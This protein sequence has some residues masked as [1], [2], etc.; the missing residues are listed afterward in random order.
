MPVDVQISHHVAEVCLRRPEKH[1]GLNLSM[2]RELNA[3]LDR[4]AGEDSLRAVVLR[5]EGPSFCAGLDVASVTRDGVGPDDL[6]IPVEGSLANLAQRAAYGWTELPV[7]VIAALHGHCLGAGLQIALG[8]DIRFASPDLVVSVMEIKWGLI[9]DMGITQTLPRLVRADIAKEL[10]WT[11][12]LVQA[13]EAEQ[14]GLVTRVVEDP[15]SAAHTMAAQIA[16]RSPDAI[17]AGKHLLTEAWNADA[18]VG[19]QL[20]ETLQR[21]LFVSPEHLSATKS[22]L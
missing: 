15:S 7:P 3:A 16:A 10:V 8:A 22:G 6:L 4:L 13:Q 1:N 17:R 14:L 2:F 5:G 9:P 20:E 11:G 19:L 18:S 21:G 12:R